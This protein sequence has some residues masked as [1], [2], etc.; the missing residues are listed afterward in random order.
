MGHVLWAWDLARSLLEEP[1]PRRWAHTQGVAEQAESLKDVLDAD[2]DLVVASAWLH[3]IGYAPN[4]AETGFHPLD[5]ARYLRSVEQADEHLCSLVAHHS[6]AVVEADERGMFDDLTGEFV[7]P[8]VDLLDVL[9]YCDMTT[10]P[11]GSH[12]SAERRIS[13]ILDRYGPDDLVH[14][15]ITRLKPDLLGTVRSVEA[16]IGDGG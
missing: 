9:T 4:L 2:A 14:R 8:R 6:G 16:R 3:D 5:G 15:A 7:L 1:L 12:L 10:G 13:E 11:D